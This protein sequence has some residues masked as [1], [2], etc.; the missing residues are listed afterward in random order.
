MRCSL[1]PQ[2]RTAGFERCGPGQEVEPVRR[3]QLFE[4]GRSCEPER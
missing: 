4:R 2:F 3:A 1:T